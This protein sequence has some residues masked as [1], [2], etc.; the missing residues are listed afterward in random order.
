MDMIFPNAEWETRLPGDLGFDADKLARVQAWLHEVAGDRPFQVGIARF[1][2]LVAEWRQGVAAGSAHSQASAAKS[3]YATLLGIVVAEGKLSSPDERVVN[4]YPEMMD[5]GEQ[6]GP[7][8]GRYALKK[9]AR[10]PFGTSS[11]M[12]RAT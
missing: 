11:A 8:P 5:V 7:K 2:Y 6:E 12:C 10:L 3:Y 4:Y 9:T 1:G